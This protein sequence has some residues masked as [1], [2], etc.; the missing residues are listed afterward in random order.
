MIPLTKP[1]YGQEE[2][3]AVKEVMESGWIAQGRKCSEF[4]KAICEYVDS[5]YAVTVS[6]C[7]SALYLSLI[8]LGIGRGDD[9]IVPD[10]TFPATALAVMQTGAR[11]VFTDV[12]LQAYSIRHR[13]FVKAIT[14]NTKAVIVVHLFGQ[15]CPG[16]NEIK[17]E[18]K[19]HYSIAKKKKIYLIEDAACSLGASYVK[20]NKRMVGIQGDL[21]CFSLHARKGI[22]TGEGGI[23]VTDD[24]R[25]AEKIKKLSAFGMERAHE[26][27]GEIQFD[28]RGFNYKMSDITA[29]IGLAQLKKIDLIIQKRKAVA[30]QWDEIIKN[31]SI[32]K[33]RLM[34]PDSYRNIYQSYTPLCDPGTRESVTNYFKH[35]GFETGIGTYA[36]HMYPDAFATRKK[37]TFVNSEYL[38]NNVISL[39]IYPD[40]DLSKEW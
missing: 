27:T 3:D 10:Y 1:Y 6:S 11:P 28:K 12:G 5:E 34:V 22:T 33:D 32:L 19:N 38:F 30:K 20:T 23:V 14:P 37:D 35:R 18:I 21:G 40:L 24:H 7:T 36:C 15:P 13:D 25:W 16:M 8:A 9:V 17:S 39:P 29:A 2:L 4:E 31:D 26:R